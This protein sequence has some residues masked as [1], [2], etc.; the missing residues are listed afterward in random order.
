[1]PTSVIAK[2]VLE[3]HLSIT[4]LG[5]DDRVLI[6]TERAPKGVMLAEEQAIWP[7]GEWLVQAERLMADPLWD[8][9]RTEPATDERLASLVALGEQLYSALFQGSIRDRWISAQSVADSQDAALHLR[10]GLRGD[11]LLQ[12]PW[13]ALY[14]DGRLL[15][16]GTD[17]TFSRY[18]SQFGRSG[19]FDAR[20]LTLRRSDSLRILVALAAP[21]DQA[22]LAVE[23]E[24][25]RLRQE[26]QQTTAHME[27]DVLDQPDREQLTHA[28]EQ[29]Q[30]HVFHYAGHSDPGPDGGS[31]HLVN[32]RTGLAEPLAG[33]DLAGLL[34]N[35]GVWLAFLNSC[36]G[37]DS[38]VYRSDAPETDADTLAA[39]L[40][41]RGV[42]GVLAMSEQIPDDVAITLMQL[43]YRNLRP[44][45]SLDLATSRMRQGL[46][47]TYGSAQFYWALPILYLHPDFDGLLFAAGVPISLPGRSPLIPNGEP[48]PTTPRS[49][50]ESGLRPPMPLK[51]L[52]DEQLA[53]DQWADQT[54][55]VNLEELVARSPSDASRGDHPAASQ[56][57]SNHQKGQEGQGH[58]FSAASSSAAASSPAAPLADRSHP[59]FDLG[60]AD[61][62]N[63]ARSGA[64]KA[65]TVPQ[66]WLVAGALAVLLGAGGL[67]WTGARS[68]TQSQPT[69]QPT[70]PI[71]QSLNPP[72][73]WNNTD[74][75]TVQA[76]ALQAL[77]QKQLPTAVQAIEALLAPNRNAAAIA[78][79]VLQTLPN[80]QDTAE[81]LFL[82]GRVTWQLARQQQP[83][84]SFNDAQRFWE[85][86]IQQNPND[87]RYHLALGFAHFQTQTLDRAEQA[88]AESLNL[89]QTADGA[90]LSDN[91][92]LTAQAGLALVA[93]ARAQQNNDSA[94]L[95]QAIRYRDQV[96]A[97]AGSQFQPPVLAQNWLWTEL[98]LSQWQQLL[99]RS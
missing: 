75:E 61:A 29:G 11:R 74:T 16:T 4:P 79:D 45:Y 84:Y 99:S 8:L 41:R 43:F 44:D 40:M 54:M 82:R 57:G 36:R 12:L 59:R 55:A 22:A 6:R 90:I 24:V 58:L 38:P 28:L 92:A 63:A 37:S 5:G 10:L 51:G 35:N 72:N 85:L 2:A 27:I 56:G 30:Y 14:G 95:Q 34:V 19:S 69:P 53:D 20:R 33:N 62:D 73:D 89:S 67:W 17:I 78:R 60:S 77:R 18:R 98:A 88:F 97:N 87:P 71:A 81:T 39:A 91:L 48:L 3:F 25:G 42:P 66:S 76:I 93:Q 31:L 49:P 9:F 80:S 70:A 47:S 46:V 7:I 21:D 50:D 86:A 94:A 52:A 68:G 23:Q 64:A 32:R 13:E 1:M 65:V 83:D 26:L 96:Q 15:T